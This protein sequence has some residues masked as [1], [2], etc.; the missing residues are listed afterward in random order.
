MDIGCVGLAGLETSLRVAV[1]TCVPSS[2][3]ILVT[4]FITQVHILPRQAAAAC[5]ACC[6]AMATVYMSKGL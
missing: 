1:H 6:V 3:N 2:A 4:T 5:Y